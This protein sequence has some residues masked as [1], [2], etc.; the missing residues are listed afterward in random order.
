MV[1][2]TTYYQTDFVTIENNQELSYIQITWLKQ[3]DSALFRQ[4]TKMLADFALRHN[5]K[6]ALIDVRRRDY[7]DKSDQNWLVR[8]IFPL[9][10]GRNIRLA[11][12][13]SPV[14]LEIM[15]TFHIHDRVLNNP[16][17]KRHIEIDIFLDKEDALKWLLQGQF[18]PV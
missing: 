9:L 15:D 10:K 2:V 7:L 16:E 3:P 13:V 5:Y 14:G 8:E 4:E 12:L 1:P 18:S 11:Y 6:F 17:L